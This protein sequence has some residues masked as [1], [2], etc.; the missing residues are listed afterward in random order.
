M[1]IIINSYTFG[2]AVTAATITV[3]TDGTYAGYISSAL[4]TYFGTTAFGSCSAPSVIAGMLW[5]RSGPNGIPSGGLVT[6]SNSGSL[7]FTNYV[8]NTINF[9]TLS[10]FGTIS[11]QSAYYNESGISLSGN[12]PITNGDIVSFNLT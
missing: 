5:D 10:N 7:V 2:A 11:G 1:S 3:G 6:F 12:L 8:T 4:A 9:N